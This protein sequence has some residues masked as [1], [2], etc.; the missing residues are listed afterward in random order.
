MLGCDAAVGG[1]LGN[2]E[3]RR[4]LRHLQ[5]M[6]PSFGVEGGEVDWRGVEVAQDSFF[7]DAHILNLTSFTWHSLTGHGVVPAGRY[8]HSLTPFG[9]RLIMF[10]GVNN[11]QVC[12][13]PLPS[14]TTS[15]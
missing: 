3:A 4:K 6:Y 7:N 14:P 15:R 13:P 8:G 9:N 12:L 11:G 10:G 2:E 1:G 5:L